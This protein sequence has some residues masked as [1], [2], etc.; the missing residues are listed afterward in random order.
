MTFGLIGNRNKAGIE[1]VLNSLVKFFAAK[2]INCI[3]DSGF[4]QA[5]PHL[6]KGQFDTSKSLVTRSD[7]VISIG[8][9]GTFLNSA[10]IIGNSQKPMIGINLG[11]LG[12]ISDILPKDIRK[13]LTQVIK[14]KYKIVELSLVNCLINKKDKLLA[15]NEI[16]IDKSDS[17]KM[18]ELEIFYNREFVGKFFSDGVLVSTPTGSTGYSLSA[19]GPII[20]P[21]SSVF[22]L[23]PICPHS[24][25]FRPVILPDDG[26]IRIRTA[27][28]EKIRITPDGHKSMIKNSP[29]ELVISKAEH[30][31]KVVKDLKWSYFNTLNKKLLWGEDV[32]KSRK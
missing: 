20:T 13:I 14:N 15:L 8:G 26:T 4:R 23:T 18:I 25:N 22:I 27:N 32:R 17:I 24:L 9:D 19:G 3:L 7:F 28:N 31:V 5:M 6:P 2:R 10:R 1:R 16:V 12:F 29:V 11:T 21:F 30:S